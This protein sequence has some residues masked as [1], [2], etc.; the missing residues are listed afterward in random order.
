MG[1]S[2]HISPSHQFIVS[3]GETGCKYRSTF[4]DTH[5]EAE[6][7]AVAHCNVHQ[8]MWESLNEEWERQATIVDDR[9]HDDPEDPMR[10]TSQSQGDDR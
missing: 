3:C 8:R 2:V 6:R 10:R 5:W 4:W 9:S 1:W 7:E